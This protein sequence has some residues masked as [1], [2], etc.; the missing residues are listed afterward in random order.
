MKFSFKTET[1]FSSSS[2]HSLWKSVFFNQTHTAPSSIEYTNL[3]TDEAVKIF[4]SKRYKLL[5]MGYLVAPPDKLSVEDA[6]F[7]GDITDCSVYFDEENN[8][9]YG[10]EVI[11]KAERISFKHK[12]L[13]NSSVGNVW[14]IF[15]INNL[16]QVEGTFDYIEKPVKI[17]YKTKNIISFLCCS[18]YQG[19]HLKDV[20][21]EQVDIDLPLHYGDEF[22]V[23][24]NKAI[25]FINSNKSGLALFHG[26]V[27]TG[28]SFYLKHL[29][30]LS[31]KKVIYVPSSLVARMAEPDFL[32]F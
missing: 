6:N 18:S 11:K 17:E 23:V 19:F 13:Y 1:N 3:S 10:V 12:T 20:Q 8:I 31:S 30:M 21:M 28:K 9:Y 14:A 26:D 32:K 22:M 29:L 4:Q 2:N 27:G 7:Y 16:S 24:H 5:S 25:E 15:N